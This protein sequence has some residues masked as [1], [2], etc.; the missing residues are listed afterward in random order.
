MPEKYYIDGK[1]NIR[2]VPDGK[3]Q[4]FLSKYPG[5]RE[6][7]NKELSDFE[8][9]RA[10]MQSS[11][12]R[13]S[14]IQ[15]GQGISTAKI[16]TNQ[17]LNGQ[18]TSFVPN[19]YNFNVPNYAEEFAKNKPQID[20]RQPDN[21][22]TKIFSGNSPFASK[23]LQESISDTMQNMPIS[24]EAYFDMAVDRYKQ[25]KD[26]IEQIK[27]DN[28]LSESVKQSLINDYKTNIRTSDDT[29]E[30]KHLPPAAKDWLERNKV[31]R[32]VTHYNPSIMGG[33]SYTTTVRE[34]TPEQIAFIKD[35]IANSED[36]KRYAQ[37]HKEFIGQ[38]EG[39]ADTLL[40]QIE[41]IRETSKKNK[42][43]YAKRHN[44]STWTLKSTNY[45]NDNI[46]DK[47]ANLLKNTKLLLSANR[48]GG[49][50]W[51]GLHLTDEDLKEL[52]VL[53]ESFYNDKV[54]N[55]VIDKYQK[56]PNSLSKEENIIIQAKY[57]ADQIN[58]GVDPG[59]WYNIGAT[60]K[61]SLPFM[62]DF[63][64][65]APIGGGVASAVKG[66]ASALAAKTGANFLLSR[67]VGGAVS[68]LAKGAIDLSVRP[69]VQTMFSPS[70]YAMAFEEMQGQAVNK[71]T[72]GNIIFD[73]RK[74]QGHGMT[75]AFIE[76]QSEVLGE[77]VLDKLFQKFR[78]P[79]P[80]FLK[81]NAAKRL[82]N[83]TGIQGPITEYA[84][85]KYSDLANIF[86]GEQTIEGF[87]DPRQNLETF[88]AVAIMQIPFSAINSTGYGI[89][90]IRDAQA[91]R[92]IRQTY[93]KSR[94]N[95]N[96]FFGQDAEIATENFNNLV[97]N[98]TEEE[99]RN[100][101]V[102]V[103]EDER[104]DDNAKRAIVEYVTA[105]SAYS[106]INKGKQEEVAQAQ[107]ETVQQVQEN[108]NPQMNAVVSATIAGFDSPVQIMGGNIVQREDGSVDREA[109]D[110]QIFY[111]DPNDGSRKVIAIDYVEAVD[112]NIPTEEATARLSELAAQ[113]VTARHE[114]EEV[115]EYQAGERV[116]TIDGAI[117]RI[118]E[119]E[120][121][122]TMT[123]ANGNY[124]LL[125]DTPAGPQQIAT[126][127][128]NIV[129]EDNLLGVENGSNVTYTNEQGQKVQGIVS[130]SSDLYAQ[131]LIAF[132][133]GDVIPITDVEG[134]V[135]EEEQ[136]PPPP[137]DMMIGDNGAVPYNPNV[138]NSQDSTQ[139]AGQNEQ[140][141]TTVPSEQ[142]ILSLD[143]IPKDEKGNILFD[144]VPVDNTISALGEVYET[145]EMPGVVD[146]TIANISKQ[147]EKI[148]S[149]KPSGDITK[150]IA[151]KRAANQ[152]LEV[153]NNRLAYWNDVKSAI[154]ANKPIKQ[155]VTEQLTGEEVTEVPTIPIE[156][157]KE[158]TV[159]PN[160]PK[161][162]TPFQRRLNAVEE[163]IHTVRDRILFGIASGSY[164]FRWRDN[165]VS[166]G[167]A[168]E[169]GLSGSE[170]E[171][172]SRIGILRNDGYTPSTLAHRI[173]EETGGELND[174]DIRSEVIDVLSSISS[175]AHALEELEKS[176]GITEEQYLQEQ[177]EASEYELELRAQEEANLLAIIEQQSNETLLSLGE[178]ALSLGATSEQLLDVQTST[179]FIDLIEQLQDGQQEQ[180]SN[181]RRSETETSNNN[182]EGNETDSTQRAVGERSRSE[183]ST[184]DSRQD[185]DST[186]NGINLSPEEQRVINEAT[187]EIDAEIAEAQKELTTQQKELSSARKRLGKAQADTQGNLFGSKQQS[188]LF[189]VPADL[190]KEN[191]VDNILSPIQQQIDAAQ[192]KLDNLTD[193]RDT[194]IQEALD[195][196]HK[197]GKVFEESTSNKKENPETI[198][199]NKL[200][201]KFPNGIK[202]YHRTTVDNWMS[203]QNEGQINISDEVDGVHT[204]LGD[205]NTDRVGG[206]KSLI[207]EINVPVEKYNRL[208]PEDATYLEDVEDAEF[209]KYD[210]IFDTYM[211]HHPEFIG[212]DIIYADNI[213]LW[214]VQIY[215]PS[216]S[217]KIAQ[218][219][220]ETDT[221]PSEA[222]KKAG[223]YKKGK[224]TI[225]RFPITIES[226]KGEERSGTDAT[227]KKWSVTLNNSYGYFRKTEGKD[228][229]HIDLFL[230]SNPQSNQVF[231]VDQVNKD[232][233][234]DEHKVMFG[235][236][237]IDEARAAYLSNYEEGWQGLGNI[238]Q[239]DI[240]TFR[241][242]TESD[243]R[244]IKPFAE[245][246]EIQESSYTPYGFS[247]EMIDYNRE[248]GA[249]IFPLNDNATVSFEVFEDNGKPYV[250]AVVE[251]HD[252]PFKIRE[253]FNTKSEA[254]EYL[255][256]RTEE[257]DNLWW[258]MQDILENKEV[259]TPAYGSSNTLVSA[260]RY[261]ELKKQMR[262]KLNGQ[263]NIGVDP[264]IFVIGAQMAM[265]HIEAGARK[266]TDFS[267]RMIEDLGEKIKPYLK[268]SY[269]AARHLPGMENLRNDMDSSE[270]VS[271]FD[272]DNFN[273]E[274]YAKRESSNI[275]PDS[276]ELL[277][278]GQV[279][280][281]TIR[282]ESAESGQD[283]NGFM[284]DDVRKV[285]S[286]NQVPREDGSID[287]SGRSNPLF[288]EEDYQ[289]ISD[290]QSELSTTD[291][292]NTRGSN[293]D[294]VGRQDD[295]QGESAAVDSES[296]RSDEGLDLVERQRS[297]KSADVVL[298]DINN[299]RE[300]L[301]VLKPEQQQDVQKAEKRYFTGA[302]QN[303]TVG[304][305]MLFTNGT[306]TGKTFT[307]VGII[308]RFLLRGIDDIIIVVPNQK[309]ASDWI[310]TADT[311]FD[312]QFQLLNDTKDQG[313]GVNVT[314][315]ANYR[316]NEALNNRHWAL[317]VYDEC[318]YLNQNA[319][320][321]PTSAQKQD[322]ILGIN[323]SEAKALAE[324][325]IGHER[326][327]APIEPDEMYTLE[328]RYKYYGNK[329]YTPEY[330]KYR[331]ELETYR[332]EKEQFDERLLNLAKEIH[333]N[334]PKKLYLSATPFAYHNSLSYADGSLFV[335]NETFD[336][337]EDYQGYNVP[338]RWESFMVE[339]FG[340]RMRY[341][342]LTV[343]ENAAAVSR[344]EQLFHEKLVSSGAVSGRSIDVPYDYS[345]DFVVV[346][347]GVGTKIDEGIHAIWNDKR[348]SILNNV[349]NKKWNYIKRAQFLEAAKSQGVK[350]H[351]DNLLANGYKVVIFHDFIK[352]NTQNPLHFEKIDDIHSVSLSVLELARLDSLR[353]KFDSESAEMTDEEILELQ[354]LE[355]I[356][357]NN[358]LE[359]ILSN[360]EKIEAYNKA[361]DIWNSEYSQ[362]ANLD[363]SDIEK[364]L[365]FFSREYEGRIG[366]FN[367]RETKR[368]RLRVADEFNKDDSGIDVILVQRQAGK[369]GISF[370]DTTGNK[371]RVL[372]NLGLPT[373]PTDAIQIEGRTY[374][375][376]LQSNTAFQYP[377]LNTS[378]EAMA[379]AYKIASRSK[380]AENLAL[381]TRARKLED[382]FKNGYQNPI[383]V[384]DIDYETIGEGSKEIDKFDEVEVSPY[385]DA[386][387]LFSTVLKNTK[388]RENREGKDYFATPEPVGFKMVEWLKSKDNDSV[389]EP[390]AGHGAIARFFNPNI[391]ATAVEPSYE[392][393]TRLRLNTT[394]E[395]KQHTFEDLHIVNKYDG[396]VMNPPFGVGGK[397]AIEHVE[398]AFKHLRTNGR[399]IAIIPNGGATEKRFNAFMESKDAKDAYLRATYV[400]PGIAFKNAG[401]NI[402]TKVV[403]IDKVADPKQITDYAPTYDY[404]KIDNIDELFDR[405]E[406][407]EAP[408]RI[409][410][411]EGNNPPPTKRVGYYDIVE[412]SNE[413]EAETVPEEVEEGIVASIE[414]YTHTKT[415]EI[416][417]IARV[418]KKLAHNDFVLMARRAKE[419]GGTWSRFAKGFL[420]ES[421]EN[422]NK[423]R[424]AEN[425]REATRMQASENTLSSIPRE[426]LEQL[427][428]TLKQTGLA[429]DV[430]IDE[431]IS[432]NPE[433]KDA[434]GNVYGYV[435]PD[436][437]IHLD[438]QNMNTNTPI[439][440]FGH[441]WND[442]IKKNNPELYQKGVE[443]IKQS[444]YYW[445]RIYNNPAYSNLSE[446]RKIDEALAMAIGDKGEGFVNRNMKQRFVDWLAEVWKSI[447]EVF[448][449]NTDVAIG[450][451]SLSDF[452][453][454]AVGELL[455]GKELSS[456]PVQS[457]ELSKQEQSEIDRIKQLAIDN[458]TYMKA[459]NGKATNL[460]ERQ[461][462]QVRSSNF[463][464]WF[465]DWE[466][467][468]KEASK[469]VDAN[470]EPLVVYHGT[471]TEFDEFIQSRNGLWFTPS[472]DSAKGYARSRSNNSSQEVVMPVFLNAKNISNKQ[473]LDPTDPNVDTWTDNTKRFN[474]LGYDGW[475]SIYDDGR[476]FTVVVN[477]PNQIKSA[478]DNTGS[479]DSN[480][481]D[482][483]FHS[484]NDVAEANNSTMT[485][486]ARIELDLKLKGVIG[487]IEDSKYAYVLE[488]LR[489][490]GIPIDKLN[491]TKMREAWEDRYLPVK[492]F[493]DVLRNRGV[494]IDEFNDFYLKATHL[495]GMN[496]SQLEVYNETLQKPLNRVIR[497]LQDKEFT[498][499]DVENYAILKHGIER[500]EWMRQNA[501]DQYVQ[502]NPDATQEQIERFTNKLPDDYA[503]VTAVEKEVG[504]TAE[505]F[506]TDFEEKAG[507]KLV[508]KFWKKV[509]EATQFSLKKNLEG[510]LLNQ[511]T[512]DE[513]TAR[514][515]YYVPLR[516]HDETVAEDR[517]DYTPQMGTYF[518]NPLIK[519][520]GRRSRSET[521]FAFIAQQAQ[522]SITA[523][524]KN[525]LNQTILR[526][527]N[528]DKT[529][530]MTVNRAWYELKG[531]QDGQ[532]I[533][534]QVQ[535]EY[536][537]DAATYLKN[538]EMF[539]VKMQKLAEAGQAFQS[540]K[541]LNIGG[542]FI[543]PKQAEQ[544]EV[545]V[546]QN[547]VDYVVY[548]NANPAV[549]KAINGSN[550]KDTSDV[551]K[552]VA[553]MSRFM[554]ANFTTRNPIFVATNFSRDYIF[555]SSIL[556]VKE[557]IKY[558]VQFQKNIPEAAGA[559]QRYI[560]GKADLTREADRYMNEY[561]I[562]GAKTGYSHIV[563]IQSVQ[564]EIEKDIKKGDK[565]NIAERV[566]QIFGAAN[567]FAEN[568][569]RFSVYMT[570]RKEGRSVVRSVS[571]AKNVTVNFNQSGAGSTIA[572]VVRPAYLFVNAGI[573][574][575]SNI[576][577]VAAK[578][579]KKISALFTFYTLS[580]A[581]IA[582]ALAM[583]LG[584]DDGLE[585]YYSLGEWERQN[586]LCL[587]TGKGFI[588]IPLP[589]ELRVFHRA[590]DNILHALTGRKDI[591]ETMIDIPLGFSDLIP[592]DPM[593]AVEAS[594]AEITP[595]FTKPFTQLAANRNFMGGRIYNEWVDP[596]TPGYLQARTNKKGNP[597]APD[598]LVNATKTLDNLTGGDGVEQGFISLNPDLVQHFARGYFGGL[599]STAMQ[600]INFTSKL[601]GFNDSGDITIR[602]TPLKTFF[603]SNEDLHVSSSSMNKKYYNIKDEVKE[604][605]RKIKGYENQANKGDIS[606][607]DFAKKI[608]SLSSDIEKLQRVYPL[609]QEID[610]YEKA[611]KELDGEDQRKIERHISDWKKQV[612]EI[613][614]IK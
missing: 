583:L 17:P 536:S 422:A 101:L 252:T 47:S 238:T 524:N 424:N 45:R 357:S 216:V 274:D 473:Y 411:T 592:I 369:E 64:L 126:E 343:P 388:R 48:E 309:I 103:I 544:H 552:K 149:P 289:G 612:I 184:G 584:G 112:E 364:P 403:I 278:R 84:E 273:S 202:L 454:R 368:K 335:I 42:E 355:D 474:E 241:K 565:R 476:I 118:A 560:R 142:N 72:Q 62:R 594:W 129:N 26:Y 569:S 115:R 308:K 98:S 4:K 382:A 96:E 550:I 420:F 595:D 186:G 589:H 323:I 456:S 467:D 227:G 515:K 485:E 76:N 19:Q 341:N 291:S 345:R 136:L 446:E 212:G 170:A 539:N 146:A 549:A 526:L 519:A 437:I 332:K 116:R 365:T 468:P 347:S 39:Q 174:N 168:R 119:D 31:S 362:Y 41:G 167:L 83:A 525:T 440:E 222:Q 95:L 104:L 409:Y 68:N 30:D 46:L 211:N 5:S 310:A 611:L 127:P 321:N 117:G 32:E 394:A 303:N 398:K 9:K 512:Y 444:P 152:Q 438:A 156:N 75:S 580:G 412:P 293:T 235:F 285:V 240:E 277:D 20:L 370:H 486:E 23:T 284:A 120:D 213:P 442:Y 429:V 591:T 460:T 51:K 414:D 313:R 172:K 196:Y 198:F 34:N 143:Q 144:S 480:I 614:S 106:G 423:F 520:N 269:E 231:V 587:Y 469:V 481:N 601:A 160:I 173:W 311:F 56:D 259:S 151:N 92:A 588:K 261:E 531:E 264:E 88:G 50:F 105:Y 586:N 378:Y 538:I 251:G 287:N 161:K 299:I 459:P 69:A 610:K 322:G 181:E 600:S 542:L 483:R 593:G 342:K 557:N 534:E 395:V 360:R 131:G 73:N 130:T 458:A 21:T 518:V 242:W 556:P 436:G 562:N 265:Y 407:L 108:I 606:V 493:F 351:V 295:G 447:K 283:A 221:N 245:Y 408:E 288:S 528:K 162:T 419:F 494:K 430:V 139:G 598:I 585:D 133:N 254:E 546:Y 461:W 189:D 8:N 553:K 147:I 599:Y 297:I 138:S 286:D 281:G 396:I 404:S 517:W 250:G 597:F 94:N 10:E 52:A 509:N 294:V 604:I 165:G 346:Q 371:P 18:N 124:I 74:T 224:V 500:N 63:I 571:D 166:M 513:L 314:T 465:G 217:D 375:I 178:E 533:W 232:R 275:Q 327:V 495:S 507:N 81:T 70:S 581:L 491:T 505:E 176:A 421:R 582:P 230:G 58:A 339:N 551:M 535:A 44:I 214:M 482:I 82:S 496:D 145:S 367:G 431:D 608:S 40:N 13:E 236:D 260:D 328:T 14:N 132:E 478:T 356:V 35:Y 234:F 60:T 609:M 305:G 498:Y 270:F 602:D 66:G 340:Y 397:T 532:P 292:G 36:G 540:G 121:G 487:K 223:N 114:N 390:S 228:K 373:A 248:H 530:L 256:N 271:N 389:L 255:I 188:K 207:L 316:Q 435:T 315:Y 38:L 334:R 206:S 12:G 497:E 169:M 179:D 158:E 268:S 462:L 199:R 366:L 363:F 488:N 107:E 154:Q 432:S 489:K 514:Y 163:N 466:N 262:D 150:D 376:G 80:A 7:T 359:S 329:D 558:A 401:T 392:L 449:I 89:G 448:S 78:I 377:I 61:Q 135:Q 330:E 86:R 243:T 613:N 607:E 575:F 215:Q 333:E 337:S 54:L 200:I 434:Q 387:A 25:E 192:T 554:A 559:L 464:E 201:E 137:A 521:P 190:S 596:N 57:I 276:Q 510:Q 247:Q 402:S 233:S 249:N 67:G 102:S 225:Q 452:T 348:I 193:S 157:R 567:E 352:G 563:E 203:I 508:E 336:S 110:K 561:I 33:G 381:G 548:I 266:F 470:G 263:L 516:G 16:P 522:S 590:G 570:S 90:K 385:R 272:I 318:H 301:P 455:S 529:G 85:E 180:T 148:N 204:V 218:A 239:V 504:M 506:I 113:E 280:Q 349:L 492:K 579:P 319:S 502:N 490:R 185:S 426:K 187:A 246:K 267:A 183:E 290:G 87:F 353:R 182:S 155:Q 427:I 445:E 53:T 220:S 372:I 358:E 573:Q 499:R 484:V 479:F 300:T 55:Q 603:T 577:K 537:S 11:T 413:S 441:L 208:F 443:L 399:M 393:A 405:L 457:T 79:V 564:K 415:G 97:D 433:I 91:T 383:Y 324:E 164:K 65:T 326:P 77:V 379:F 71:D 219:E 210:M 572:N 361:V 386:V 354:D 177:A 344:L 24:S 209:D 503:G 2:V 541:K 205:P 331:E 171:R 175:R 140:S 312:E 416:L 547:G 302:G 159:K 37:A 1:G 226:V 29:V 304:A 425:T 325:R 568:L 197:Q 472:Y 410:D 15:N 439:H 475:V 229:D 527:A 111:V 320:G 153:L 237:T 545:H 282:S 463:K 253:G 59:S 100:E 511:K 191:A 391:T 384:E 244:R 471:N 279:D 123:D 555:A 99:L 338:D 417:A 451:M 22:P 134:L 566:F 578:N 128:R 501:I 141:V 28:T 298:S 450:D 400:L 576:A 307:G 380:T 194:H 543:K 350:E 374:R 27:N 453:D 49:G 3:E 605:R 418:E 257:I 43:E 6:A 574:A 477:N 428:D 258:D 122:S 306:G 296:Q 523:S 93:D 109:S 317:I 195:N 406:F 125:V